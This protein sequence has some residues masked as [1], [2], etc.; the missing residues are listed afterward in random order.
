MAY[1]NVNYEFLGEIIRRVSGRPLA[2]LAQ[3]RIFGPLGMKDSYYV[4]PDSV[5]ARILK[6]P[7][8]AP[9]GRPMGWWQGINSPEH[10]KT[11]WAF[12]GLFSTA[13]DIAIFGQ[14]FLNGGSYGRTRL[15]SGPAVEAMTRNQ[16]PGIGARM[17]EF[18]HREASY[19]YGWFVES[20]EKWK[21]YGATLAPPGAFWH[22]GAGGCSLWID[23]AEEIVGVYLEV[24]MRVTE[25]LEHR[26][27][28]D[29]FHDLVTSAVAD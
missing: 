24:T 23:P 7:T 14:T 5:R 13:R 20:S 9:Y 1:C 10:E 19:G 8:T 25:L 27:N 4:V 29:L 18:F 26:W 16:I 11:P 15:L 28:Y 6:R 12:G 21:Y 17:G 3:E 22:M 2:D